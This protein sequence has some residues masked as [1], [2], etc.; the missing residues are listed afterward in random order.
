MSGSLQQRR[1]SVERRIGNGRTQLRS[2]SSR[3]ME[4][5]KRLDREQVE[6]CE[7]MLACASLEADDYEMDFC[8]VVIFKN[9]PLARCR[10][11]HYAIYRAAIINNPTEAQA[12][13]W[14]VLE[15]GADL[16]AK[17]MYQTKK[18]SVTI[19]AELEAIHLA[20]GLGCVPAL[21]ALL[22]W[23]EEKCGEDGS[24]YIRRYA[25]VRESQSLDD[26]VPFYC[27]IHEATYQGHTNTISWLLEKNA[28]AAAPNKDG[29]TPLHF[30]ALI[31]GTQSLAYDKE[32]EDIVRK[33]IANG[34]SLEARSAGEVLPYPGM[35]FLQHKIPLEIAAETQY[36][37][38][39]LDLLAP[40]S[41]TTTGRSEPRLFADI[42]LLSQRNM[43]VAEGYA[44]QIR[45]RAADPAEATLKHALAREAQVPGHVDRL[46][47]MIYM[48]PMA[49]A[50]ILD[51]LTEE[52]EVQ[53]VAKHPIPA[54]T[55][56]A[57]APMR[58]TYQ[59]DATRRNGILMPQWK[60]DAS[61][62]DASD[63][64]SWHSKLI[65]AS[66]LEGRQDDVYDVETKVCLM[67]NMMDVDVFMALSRTWDVH[68][69]I[70]ARLPV[71]GAV[72]CLWDNLVWRIFLQ[73]WLSYVLEL[74]SLMW[75]GLVDTHAEQQALH[76]ASGRAS[77]TA[78]I[79]LAVLL[80]GVFREGFNVCWWALAHWSKWHSHTDPKLKSLWHPL[81]LLMDPWF[82][83][84]WLLW[85][86]RVALCMDIWRILAMTSS[87]QAAKHHDFAQALLAF[88]AFVQGFRVTYMFRLVHRFKRILVIFKTFFSRTIA[89]MSL[90]ACMVFMSFSFAFLML[91]RS[92][93]TSWV[94]VYLYRGLIF[95]DGDGLDKMGL[96]AEEDSDDHPALVGFMVLGTMV[97]NV[98]IMNL[99]VAIYGNEYDMMEQETTL[100]FVKER[101]KYCLIYI[102][103]LH[104]QRVVAM[105]KEASS[106]MPRVLNTGQILYR[107]FQIEKL[108]SLATA[109]VL[110]L[111]RVRS[112]RTWT[113]AVGLLAVV[114]GFIRAAVHW[115]PGTCALLLALIGATLEITL[116]AVL[117]QAD[118]FQPDSPEIAVGVAMRD[119][120]SGH[121]GTVLEQDE[122]SGGWLL[123][124][125]A[126]GIKQDKLRNLTDID[127]AFEVG[128]RVEV[129]STK[130]QGTL[131][132]VLGD[133]ADRLRLASGFQNATSFNSRRRSTSNIAGG[134]PDFYNPKWLVEM[135]DCKKVFSESTLEFV[136]PS[137]F[138]WM[139]HRADFDSDFLC[140]KEFE[141]GK[142]EEKLD[143]L[144]E[145][146]NRLEDKVDM[147][148][149]KLE[150]GMDG[151]PHSSS[152]QTIG[153]AATPRVRSAPA[154]GLGLGT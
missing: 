18:G 129:I 61:G 10:L 16:S 68:N 122:Q 151:V 24:T 53:D 36:P 39:L 109:S 87:G 89:E 101:C 59:T 4:A 128:S 70:F 126:L 133:T 57:G 79:C 130:E 20:A 104:K 108:V 13:V 86:P 149:Q 137:R 15:A 140:G 60:F 98:T 67:P 3:V 141:T 142:L 65:E 88:N 76:A 100:L 93:Q 106:A 97:F 11:L 125:D 107:L 42:I 111:Y 45:E 35:P 117:V 1:R 91:L 41:Q 136:Q 34:A 119:I 72:Y 146:F 85:L 105:V 37:K 19:E 154:V 102:Q 29:V 120:P 52:P 82:V 55:K 116:Q 48:V 96:K 90:I 124:M 66:N 103:M 147:I 49:A 6:L 7:A 21:E 46:A 17:A 8:N 112:W 139:C 77:V 12:A 63:S 62:S 9:R 22:K 30:V 95:G 23:A 83:L 71:Q 40:S 5:D 80:S 92:R 47:S 74:A 14:R 145:R 43:A 64:S 113:A 26:A 123:Q 121:T 75:W 2:R 94:V 28:D 150:V 51:I 38:Q 138:L 32:V 110:Q 134:G 50:D 58:C 31:A 84:T 114:W 148:C 78:T 81:V 153:I 118:W 27:P 127:A 44:H 132:R 99:F 25:T 69:T 135:D 73:S 33:L 56:L 152:A 144:A 143:V 54:R 131:K 115:A